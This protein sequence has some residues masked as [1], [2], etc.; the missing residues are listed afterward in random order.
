MEKLLD[1][2]YRSTVTT[3]LGQMPLLNKEEFKSM[4]EELENLKSK[5]SFTE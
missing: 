2:I 3:Q 5:V 4:K 1:T